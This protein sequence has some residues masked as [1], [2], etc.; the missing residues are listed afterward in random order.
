MATLA[1]TRRV[2]DAEILVSQE[3]NY[4]S[5]AAHFWPLATPTSHQPHWVLRPSPIPFP[6]PGS[7]VADTCASSPSPS[8]KPPLLRSNGAHLHDEWPVF[9]EGLGDHFHVHE[10]CAQCPGSVHGQLRPLGVPL[11]VEQ[12]LQAPHHAVG[13]PQTLQSRSSSHAPTLWNRSQVC[14]VCCVGLKAAAAW[15]I[16][17]FHSC[18]DETSVAV[19]PWRCS[20]CSEYS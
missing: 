19:S 3:K 2:F 17:A 20:S 16:C 1:T 9:G 13:D 5:K 18:A 14:S 6:S 15:F 4:E 10:I 12:R 8:P 7:P 11:A